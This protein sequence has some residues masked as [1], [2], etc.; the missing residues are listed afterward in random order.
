MFACLQLILIIPSSAKCLAWSSRPS[1]IRPKRSPPSSAKPPP[2]RSRRQATGPQAPRPQNGHAARGRC[3]RPSPHASPP[4]SCNGTHRPAS[5]HHSIVNS[6]ICKAPTPRPRTRLLSDQKKRQSK[7]VIRA[8]SV[9]DRCLTREGGGCPGTKKIFSGEG[10]GSVVVC[11]PGEGLGGGQPE[12]QRAARGCGVGALARGGGVEHR[13]KTL[14]P[15]RAPAGGWRPWFGR[16]P[17]K[18]VQ[19]RSRGEGAQDRPSLLQSES[20][21]S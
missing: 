9:H 1:L 3:P 8:S 18:R 19:T 7:L 17:S 10:G 14:A 15:L 2:I 13:P 16:G 6:M 21:S 12:R 4:A 20:F 5:I 11:V